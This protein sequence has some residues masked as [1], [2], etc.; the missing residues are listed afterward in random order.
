MQ[1][2]L[3]AAIAETDASGPRHEA[4]AYKPAT[5]VTFVQCLNRRPFFSFR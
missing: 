2:A 5:S 4:V 1:C 3:H